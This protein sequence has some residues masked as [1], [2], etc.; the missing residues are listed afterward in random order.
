M[1]CFR[2]GDGGQ[3][4]SCWLRI[5][6]LSAESFDAN[7]RQIRIALVA[8]MRSEDGRCATGEKAR[9]YALFH[10]SPQ[11][12]EE[13]HMERKLGWGL[14][15]ASTIAR[16]WMIDAIRA[17]PGNDVVAVLSSDAKRGAAYAAEHG[18]GA[19]VT[20]IDALLATPGVDAV[21]ISTTNELHA[22]Q[23]IAAARAGK[24][25]LCEKP[26]A[27][28]LG[29]AQAIIDAC[30][31]AGVVLATNHHLRNAASH[32]AIRR[33]VREGSIG[34]PLFA[35]VFHAVRLPG[36]LQGWRLQKPDAGG[37]VI[38]DITVH[39]ADTLRFILDAEP[40]EAIAMAQ[41]DGPVEDAV[42]AVL[43]F[44]NGVLA[45]LH[46]AFN[47]PHA[48]TGIEIHGSAG[49]IIGRDVMTQ[50]SVGDILLRTAAGERIVHTEPHNLYAHSL[51]LFNAAVR[52]EGAPSATG[53]DGL[54]SLAAAL[55]VVEASRT[56]RCT[57]VKIR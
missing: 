50:R 45:Q 38:L 14:V 16:E 37:G 43:R 21:Y 25:V 28:T 47:V 54:R 1:A 51:E 26:L 18:I 8:C 2:A 30:R 13:M 12:P 9:R 6:S 46:D 44:D 48:G 29:D 49:S 52:G 11:R 57:P 55:A 17:Q 20:S 31:S 4:A 41:G 3:S 42:M 33:L 40:V 53:E 39:D 23:A 10:L 34:E 5:V 15:G 7:R 35:R 56:G 22:P 36:H 32:Q 24:H 27:M 19:S